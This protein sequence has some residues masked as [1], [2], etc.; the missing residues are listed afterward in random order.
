M[1]WEETVASLPVACSIYLQP[2]LS[3]PGIVP[4]SHES[5][6]KG[7]SEISSMAIILHCLLWT[8]VAVL[9]TP[10]GYIF[11]FCGFCSHH[12]REHSKEMSQIRGPLGMFQV[13]IYLGKFCFPFTLWLTVFSQNSQ[14]FHLLWRPCIFGVVE[15]HTDS[16]SFATCDFIEKLLALTMDS[17]TASED[18]LQC[19]DL[20]MFTHSSPHWVE[21][22]QWQHLDASIWLW[23]H[24]LL[25]YNCLPWY[26]PFQDN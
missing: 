26:L 3:N 2:I 14:R 21:I 23:K 16:S 19:L 4:F 18:A 25:F 22:L 15:G 20:L 5:S 12:F 6:S 17:H 8:L 9:W 24:F 10:S 7:P 13:L 1:P 11:L